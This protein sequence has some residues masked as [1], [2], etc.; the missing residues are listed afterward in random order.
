MQAIVTAC[1]VRD[2]TCDEF[3]LSQNSTRCAVCNHP[4]ATHT[5]QNST[6]LSSAQ[7]HAPAPS[8]PG[9]SVEDH[10]IQ[11]MGHN[12]RSTSSSSAMFGSLTTMAEVHRAQQKAKS[13]N[14]NER[15]QDTEQPPLGSQQHQLRLLQPQRFPNS[16]RPGPQ[17]GQQPLTS[18]NVNLRQS[19]TFPS[20]APEIVEIGV[21][22]FTRI[23]SHH[24]SRR[25]IIFRLSLNLNDNIGD[26]HQYLFDLAMRHTAW[27]ERVPLMQYDPD[28]QRQIFVGEVV[29]AAEPALSPIQPRMTGSVRQLLYYSLLK[30]DLA[31][32]GSTANGSKRPQASTKRQAM[33]FLALVIPVVMLEEEAVEPPRR[34][35]TVSCHFCFNLYSLFA[36][37]SRI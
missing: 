11:V 21:V 10:D 31:S 2:C 17:T 25:P 18:S 20:L 33:R 37:I 6:T 14:Q 22:L 16:I 27:V 30:R 15:S 35:K 26:W 13:K 19:I 23:R 9:T 7:Q 29:G 5:T 24:A 4:Q 8:F 1:S 12:T 3:F 32:N 28:P 36:N 34:L